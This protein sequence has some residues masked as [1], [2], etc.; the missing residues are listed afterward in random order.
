[1]NISPKQF[2]VSFCAKSDY[3]NMNCVYFTPVG[4]IS[5]EGHG[6]IVIPYPVQSE[7]IPT[8]E[9]PVVIPVDDCKLVSKFFKACKTPGPSI[10]ECGPDFL[11]FESADSRFMT[12]KRYIPQDGSII[13]FRRI[14]ETS[15]EAIESDETP[16]TDTLFLRVTKQLISC[17]E[18]DTAVK[19]SITKSTCSGGPCFKLSTTDYPQAYAVLL[20]RK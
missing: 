5:S 11:R 8:W 7:T 12:I 4:A 13:D 3:K 18:R 16:F 10:M 14:I 20:S 17:C 1:M 2:S 19:V 9:N 15:N 6:F